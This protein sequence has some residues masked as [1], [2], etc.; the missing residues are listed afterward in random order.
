MERASTDVKHEYFDGYIYLMAGGSR[1]HSTLGGNAYSLL[2]EAVADGPCRTYNSDM[3]VRLSESVQVY[4]D[5]TVTCDERDDEN[6]E[7]DEIAY[8]RLVLEVLSPN[9]ER[10]DRGRKLRYYQSCPTIEEYALVNSDY[11][12]IEVYRRGTGEWTY[13]RFEVGDEV[14]LVSIGAQI[15]IAEYYRQTTVPE[16]PP[17]LAE[18]IGMPTDDAEDVS[19]R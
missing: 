2:R 12:A 17:R 16:S 19:P 7:D 10:I 14:E 9:T 1:R 4:P 6:A 3:R 11:Q 5:A 15:P 13:R 18:S 8:P